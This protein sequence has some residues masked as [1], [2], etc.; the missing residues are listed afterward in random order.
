M[1]D[2]FADPPPATCCDQVL[3]AIGGFFKFLLVL[4]IL[5][6]GLAFGF[7][8]FAFWLVFT[9]LGG[10]IGHYICQ[11][12][13]EELLAKQI[14]SE[15]NPDGPVRL[16]RMPTSGNVLAV[17]WTPSGAQQRAFPVCIPNGLG[18]TLVT[19]SR[20]HERLQELGFS[21]LSYVRLVVNFV[22]SDQVGRSLQFINHAAN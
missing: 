22:V 17:R 20:L 6:L 7:V 1:E 16:L 3:S 14:H 21:V 2:P 10:A 4:V 19:I 12:S 15:S 11:G 5:P 13:D 8:G 9:L 18:A